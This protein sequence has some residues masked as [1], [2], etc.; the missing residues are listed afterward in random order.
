[1]FK[2]QLKVFVPMKHQQV[3][4]YH[5]FHKFL[6]TYEEMQD[7]ETNQAGDLRH[8]RLLRSGPRGNLEENLSN[9][10]AV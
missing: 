4:F 8:V 3:S 6:K 1:M 5:D 9:M 10:T 2:D 7:K